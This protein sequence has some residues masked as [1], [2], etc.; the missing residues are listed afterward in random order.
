MTNTNPETGVRYGIINAHSIDPEILNTIQMEGRDVLY[1]A[2]KAELW[3]D[4]KRVCEDFMSDKDSDEVA[5]L[6]VENMVTDYDELIHEHVIDG[7]QVRTTWLGGG[8][9]IWVFE[10]PFL[11]TYAQCS[12]CVPGAGDLNT[13]DENGVT[14]YDVPPDWRIES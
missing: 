4:V 10:S 3:A 13:P 12:P 9:L 5:D 6:A 2:D 11:G 8:L 7:V 14:C 1:E